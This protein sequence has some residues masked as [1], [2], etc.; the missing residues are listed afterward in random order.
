V[1]IAT[2]G[3]IGLLVDST[4]IITYF[5]GGVMLPEMLWYGLLVFIPI[6]FLGAQIAKRIVDKIPQNKFR[7]VIAIF[8]L[9]AGFKILLWP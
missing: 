3:A 9:L 8:L 1:Y 7:T 5:I 6:S 4:R 2:A